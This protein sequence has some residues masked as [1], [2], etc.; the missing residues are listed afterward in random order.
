MVQLEI[1]PRPK[2][3]NVKLGTKSPKQKPVKPKPVRI[4]RETK[5]RKEPSWALSVM[6]PFNS[7]G[8]SIPDDQANPSGKVSS[9]WHGRI[10]PAALTG[11]STTHTFGFIIPPYVKF[12]TLVETSAGNVTLTDLNAAGTGWAQDYN[13]ANQ[14]A[15]TGGAGKLRCTGLGVRITYQG[16][17]LNRSATL[18]AGL[19]PSTCNPASVASTGT[20]A[21]ALST[22]VGGGNVVATTTQIRDKMTRISETRL[23]GTMEMI[24]VPNNVPKYFEDGTN[25]LQFSTTAGA[26]FVGSTIWNAKEGEAGAETGQNWLVF[27]VEGDTTSAASATSNVYSIDITWNWE[28][29]PVTVTTVSHAITPSHCDPVELAKCVNKFQNLGIAHTV[30][31]GLSGKPGFP[32]G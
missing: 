25:A 2:A 32:R 6:R 12:L 31:T 20:Y 14:T 30:G 3:K 13:V 11:T 18:V 15:L 1:P 19:I 28:A 27:F 8:V 9:T 17:E 5:P 23:N 29:I 26:A 4:K 10:A 21:S 7:N 16:T 24:W 22:L